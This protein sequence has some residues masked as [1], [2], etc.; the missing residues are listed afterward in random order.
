MPPPFPDCTS[1]YL[2]CGQTTSVSGTVTAA[3]LNELT[4]A[5]SNGIITDPLWT[6][7]LPKYG[8]RPP[9]CVLQEFYS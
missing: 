6:P 1:K 3:S 5:L 7:F 2:H 9:K 4:Y 8:P